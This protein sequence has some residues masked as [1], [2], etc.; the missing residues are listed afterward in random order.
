MRRSL[1]LSSEKRLSW[2]GQKVEETISS[3]HAERRFFNVWDLFIE[4]QNAAFIWWKEPPHCDFSKIYCLHNFFLIFIQKYKNHKKNRLLWWFQP[5]I[6][7]LFDL[8]SSFGFGLPRRRASDGKWSGVSLL[9]SE[10]RNLL[11]LS[12]WL[13]P[14][15]QIK[16]IIFSQNQN[17]FSPFLLIFHRVLFRVKMQKRKG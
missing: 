6:I 12:R 10:R 16:K 5:S 9:I 7:E 2:F 3:D 13:I 11:T 14:L 8:D 1:F 4:I 15:C 17:E